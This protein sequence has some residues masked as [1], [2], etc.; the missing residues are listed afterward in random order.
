[1]QSMVAPAKVNLALHVTGRRVDG[2]H[3][4]DSLVV[5]ADIGDRLWLTPAAQMTLDVGGRFA[6]GVPRDSRNLVWR[7]A[8]LAGQSLRIRL[9]KNLPHGAGIGGGSSDAAAVVGGEAV[10]LSRVRLPPLAGPPTQAPSSFSKHCFEQCPVP[11]ISYVAQ[12]STV[13]E[14]HDTDLKPSTRLPA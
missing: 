3:L 8:E 12:G 7:A 2:Y 11:S 1:M 4:L 14:R 13:L 6:D 9:E 10:P 5:F